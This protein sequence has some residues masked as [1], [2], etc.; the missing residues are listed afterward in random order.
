M[1]D[2]PRFNIVLKVI[3]ETFTRTPPCSDADVATAV[4][5]ALDLATPTPAGIEVR[6]AV[7][8]D[9][10]NGDIRLTRIY[11][12]VYGEAHAWAHLREHEDCHVPVAIIIAHVTPPAA[13][14]VVGRVE[15]T[16]T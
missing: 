11:P 3:A 6:A 15:G 16:E 14:A 10:K 7:A 1:A 12:G 8:M 13:Q 2:D 4:L 9:P 5:A